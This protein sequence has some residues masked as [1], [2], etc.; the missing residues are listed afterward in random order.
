MLDEVGG[1]AK[2]AACRNSNN[3]NSGS[4]NPNISNTSIS[5]VSSA[6]PE[7]GTSSGATSSSG[8]GG[9]SAVLRQNSTSSVNSPPTNAQNGSDHSNTNSNSSSVS[10]SLGQTVES[11]LS[12]EELAKKKQFG[13]RED[14]SG[15]IHICRQIYYNA[16]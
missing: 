7:V 2:N 9:G 13:N 15:N 16:F 12:P 14:D 11:D 3:N 4:G 10:A 6:G 1:H 8:A 5:S